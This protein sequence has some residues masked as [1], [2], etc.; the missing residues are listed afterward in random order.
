MSAYQYTNSWFA[1]TA[2]GNW[3]QLIPQLNPQRI[4][5]IGSYEGASTCYLIDTL[6]PRTALEI[7]CVDTWE[8]GAEHQDGGYVQTDMSRVEARFHH[9]TQI[10]IGNAPN[11]VDLVL[12]KGFSDIELSRLLA[13]GKQGYFDFIYV[14]GSHQA[15]DVLCDALL[16]FRLLRKNGVIA[17]DDYLWHEPLPY[18][19]DPI[20]CPKPAIDAFTNL[21]CRMIRIIPAPLYQ[22]YVEKTGG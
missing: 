13:D 19:M 21:Y 5:E 14:D 7:H 2:K 15:P 17:F 8:G 18:G 3:D 12:H 22:L 1:S 10:A 9:N 20:R 4:L 16:S 11:P 6:G